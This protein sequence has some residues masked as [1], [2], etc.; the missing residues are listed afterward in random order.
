MVVVLEKGR[1]FQA[2]VECT[3]KGNSGNGCGAKLGVNRE[4]MR[5]FAGGGW[6]DRDAAV[7][8]RCP[9]CGSITDLKRSQ[10]PD[11]AGSLTPFTT[12]WAKSGRDPDNGPK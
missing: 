11:F 3:G 5:Y 1:G 6:A 4:D 8:I 12:A 10:W 9:D 2:I 7:V